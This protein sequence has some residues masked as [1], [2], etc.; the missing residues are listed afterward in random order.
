MRSSDTFIP[1]K[2][3]SFDAVCEFAMLHHVPDP[4]KVVSEM[5]RVAKNAIFQS[6]YL[7]SF[8]SGRLEPFFVF[9]IGRVA[10]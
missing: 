6:F 5:I 9:K 10:L 4:D 1:L 2:N 7:S 3:N 8:L